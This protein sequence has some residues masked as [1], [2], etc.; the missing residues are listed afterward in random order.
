[1]HGPASPHLGHR[2]V[3]RGDGGDSRPTDAFEAVRLWLDQRYAPLR[4]PL[5]ISIA[6]A[7]AEFAQSFTKAQP[8]VDADRILTK[9]NDLVTVS[10][11]VH[12]LATATQAL[13]TTFG[14]GALAH[15]ADAEDGGAESG[16]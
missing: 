4:A 3:K 1:V 10:T 15:V 9:A 2:D 13:V 8:V 12:W 5:A 6:R 7:E 11:N 14:V 16:G